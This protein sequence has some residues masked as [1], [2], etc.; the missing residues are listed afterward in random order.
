MPIDQASPLQLYTTL[1][2]L[3][4]DPEINLLKADD[5]LYPPEQ[6]IVE[7]GVGDCKLVCVKG[8]EV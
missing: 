1:E 4:C 8:S 7:A 2:Q 5:R 3:S 6:Q